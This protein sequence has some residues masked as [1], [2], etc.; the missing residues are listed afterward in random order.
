M[1]VD[2]A[3]TTN[4]NIAQPLEGGL[5]LQYDSGDMC[6]PETEINSVGLGL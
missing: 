4:C 6:S 5:P 3:P 1:A 2:P